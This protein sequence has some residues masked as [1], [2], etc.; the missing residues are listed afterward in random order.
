MRLIEDIQKE[1]A[2]T[3]YKA[4]EKTYLI[5]LK[6]EEIDKIQYEQ[7]KLL[8]AH[9]ER[10]RSFAEKTDDYKEIVTEFLES[11]PNTSDTFEQLLVMSDCGPAM[12]YELAKN[13]AEF[14]RI[15]SLPPI[16]AARELGKLEYRLTSSASDD[17]KPEPKKT[18]KAPAPISP[19]GSKGGRVEKSPEDMTQREFEAWRAKSRSA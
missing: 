6:N 1:Y 13:P 19:V 10:E 16:A 12:L 8:N 2:E 18:T 11:K 5:H 3:V 14:E 17:T 9:Y 4:G 15:N 7:E